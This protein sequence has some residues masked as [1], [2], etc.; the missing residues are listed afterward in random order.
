MTGATK[1][2]RSHDAAKQ[3]GYRAGLERGRAQGAA[4]RLRLRQERDSLIR[5]N[6]RLLKKNATL[7]ERVKK[8]GFK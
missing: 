2:K 3:R 8:K 7:E 6:E 4:E 5:T 1:S